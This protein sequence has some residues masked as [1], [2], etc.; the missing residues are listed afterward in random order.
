MH[1]KSQS[2]WS[3]FLHVVFAEAWPTDIPPNERKDIEEALK[4][5]RAS[6][7]AERAGIKKGSW[8]ERMVATCRSKLSVKPYA[9]RAVLFYSQL[10]TGEEDLQS[11]H[12]GCP[13]LEGTKWAANL[14]VWNTPRRD[15]KGAPI[16]DGATLHQGPIGNLPEQLLAT[17]ENTGNDPAMKN[18]VLYYDEAQYWGPLGPN[19]PQL[20]SNTYEGHR[21][22]H[23]YVH[24]H[25]HYIL[26]PCNP[27]TSSVPLWYNNGT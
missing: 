25:D 7:D 3:F 16:R 22:V 17:F 23:H 15:H 18:A 20:R 8:E 13:V 14:W 9:G 5:L 2:V 11:R 6:G 24:L 12:G 4:E 27:N 19:D 26:S 21:Y 10:G 1:V